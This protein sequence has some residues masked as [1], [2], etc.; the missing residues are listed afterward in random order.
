MT[1]AWRTGS[2][3]AWHSVT[4]PAV[5]DASGIAAVLIDVARCTTLPLPNSRQHLFRHVCKQF[6]VNPFYLFRAT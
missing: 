2:V 6:V 3:E 1:P 4:V 5:A